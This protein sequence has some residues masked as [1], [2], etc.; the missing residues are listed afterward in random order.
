MKNIQNYL[1]KHFL[2][3]ITSWSTRESQAPSSLQEFIFYLI[4]KKGKKIKR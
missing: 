4:E 2:M 3:K 1:E